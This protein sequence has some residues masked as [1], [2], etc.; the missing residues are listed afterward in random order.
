MGLMEKICYNSWTPIQA[1]ASANELGKFDLLELNQKVLFF[2][3]Q[4][5]FFEK[6]DAD[7][8]ISQF[9]IKNNRQ[10]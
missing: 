10:H 7:L 2:W 8:W 1:A 4:E 5:G 3:H 9:K 6:L